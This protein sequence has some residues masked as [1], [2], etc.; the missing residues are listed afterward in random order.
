MK[1]A[2]DVYVPAAAPQEGDA[3]RSSRIYPKKAL[4]VNALQQS[5]WQLQGVKAK[6]QTS[7]NCCYSSY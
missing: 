6:Q 7:V 1:A 5:F 3:S 4:L 2:Y